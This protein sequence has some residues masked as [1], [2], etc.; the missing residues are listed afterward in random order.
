V[1]DEN[2]FHHLE[3]KVEGLPALKGK[4]KRDGPLWKLDGGLNNQNETIMGENIQNQ[5]DMTCNYLYW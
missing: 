1:I 4:H 5:Q 3:F 2:S